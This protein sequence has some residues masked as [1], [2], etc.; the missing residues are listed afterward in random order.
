MSCVRKPSNNSN[1]T[2][3]VAPI[4]VPTS[5]AGPR[6]VSP[7]TAVY[8]AD[9]DSTHTTLRFTGTA[10]VVYGVEYSAIPTADFWMPL[11]E[12]RADADGRFEVALSLRGNFTNEWASASFFRITRIAP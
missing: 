7:G 2:H 12:H 3:S 11:G 4:A 10:N 6:L 1:P 9:N 8:L 5:T